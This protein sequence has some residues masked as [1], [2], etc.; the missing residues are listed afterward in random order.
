MCV[1]VCVYVCVFCVLLCARAFLVHV[2]VM[3]VRKRYYMPMRNGWGDE[4]V[5]DQH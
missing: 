5:R 2:H 1:C 3:G 4:T